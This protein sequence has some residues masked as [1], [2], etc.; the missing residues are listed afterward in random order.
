MAVDQGLLSVLTLAVNL[1][2]IRLGT[3]SEYALFCIITSCILL[4]QSIQNGALGTPLVVLGGRVPKSELPGL[5]GYLHRINGAA[6]LMAAALCAGVAYF[7][8]RAHGGRSLGLP[9]GAAIAVL[10]F[11]LREYRRTNQL[12]DGLFRGL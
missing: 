2:L 12:R 3:K 9:M 6:A 8:P 5:L 7:V 4:T 1:V 10:G 11:W